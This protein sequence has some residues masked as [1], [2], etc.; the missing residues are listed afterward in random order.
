MSELHT[1]YM[2]VQIERVPERN[3]MTPE[4]WAAWCE[5]KGFSAYGDK[6]AW[7]PQLKCKLHGAQYIVYIDGAWGCL[8]TDID[9]IWS[10]P[11]SGGRPMDYLVGLALWGATLIVSYQFAGFLGLA[12]CGLGLL[13][14]AITSDPMPP[15]ISIKSLIMKTTLRS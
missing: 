8:A 1:A 11:D 13:Y 7:I 3:N 4:Q 12:I 5:E 10:R 9:L 6:D 15:A 2:E 14:L